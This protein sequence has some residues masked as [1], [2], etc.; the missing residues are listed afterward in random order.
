MNVKGTVWISAIALALLSLSCSV[1]AQG[2]TPTTNAGKPGSTAW[3][4][5][6]V[7]NMSVDP[8]ASV[9]WGSASVPLLVTGPVGWVPNVNWTTVPLSINS[10]CDVTVTVSEGIGD[11]LVSEGIPPEAIFCQN[12]RSTNYVFKPAVSLLGTTAGANPWDAGV[13]YYDNNLLENKHGNLPGSNGDTAGTGSG[14]GAYVQAWL[15]YSTS[16]AWGPGS[17]GWGG[18]TYSGH[19][20]IQTAVGVLTQPNVVTVGTKTYD[21]TSLQQTAT[22]TPHVWAMITA[23][24]S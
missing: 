5:S 6:M 11:W 18:T 20:T 21:W 15:S 10:N 12:T 16:G 23:G 4:A 14:V 17:D 13:P 22:G 9:S 8:Y 7:L 1:F 19:E 3:G 2:I 24:T